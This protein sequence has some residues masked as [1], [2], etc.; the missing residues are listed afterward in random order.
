MWRKLA[1]T[2]RTGGAGGGVPFSPGCASWRIAPTLAPTLAWGVR[3]SGDCGFLITFVEA[4]RIGV[5][6]DSSH[7]VVNRALAPLPGETAGKVS[8]SGDL[9]TSESTSR[10]RMRA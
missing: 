8:W 5:Q 10:A 2:A 6:E 1:S 9:G 3:E 4:A 7:S